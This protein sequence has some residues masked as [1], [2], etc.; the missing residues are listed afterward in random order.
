ME[1]IIKRVKLI[2]YPSWF[3][4]GLSATLTVS[5]QKFNIIFNTLI[6]KE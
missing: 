2:N 3:L 1:R 5:E 4:L 6:L